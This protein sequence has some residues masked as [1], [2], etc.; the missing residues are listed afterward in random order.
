MQCPR[1]LPPVFLFVLLVMVSSVAGE[2]PRNSPKL[3]PSFDSDRPS[4]TGSDRSPV[5]R[6][7]FQRAVEKVRPSARYVEAKGASAWGSL[8]RNTKK[9]WVKTKE[10][11]SPWNKK[12]TS[13]AKRGFSPFWRSSSKPPTAK[14]S[15]FKSWFVKKEPRPAPSTVSDWIGRPKP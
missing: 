10:T 4:V 1:L 9:L 11:L 8:N 12:G 14:P 7:A 2:S 6:T 3:I 5:Q 15:L 13:K